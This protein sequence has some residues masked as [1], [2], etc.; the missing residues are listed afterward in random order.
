MSASLDS[1]RVAPAPAP[2]LICGGRE[3]VP[4]FPGAG[5]PPPGPTVTEHYR[6]THSERRLVGALVRCTACGMVSLPLHY[7]PPAS[8]DEAADPWYLEQA[9]ERIANAHRLLAL[10]PGS[11]RLLEIG[12][13]CGFLLVAARDRGFSVRGVE[14]SKWASAYARDTFGL[15]VHTGTLESAAVPSASVDVVVMA[16]VIEHL[17][18][19]AAVLREIHRVLAPGGRLLLLTPDIGSLAARL[20]GPRWWALLDDHYYYFSR[21]TLRRLLTREGFAVERLQA[22]GRAFPLAHWAFKLAPYS[23]TL[24]RTVSGALRAVRAERVQLSF[25]LGDQMACVAQKR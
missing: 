7:A 22:L 18:D 21:D 4:H 12:C 1:S 25:N 10:L 20:A 8:Y 6:I 9:Q 15:D 24:E 16:D 23:R 13:A 2:C 3:T 14:M 5:T 11:G 17:F 19:P